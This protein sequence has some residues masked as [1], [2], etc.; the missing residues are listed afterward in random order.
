MSQTPQNIQELSKEELIEFLVTTFRRTL[1]HYGLWFREAEYQ[2]GMKQAMDAEDQAFSASFAIHM[3]RLSKILG[4]EVDP[5]GMPV[6]LLNQ[7]RERILK[8]IEAQSAN[9]LANDGVWFQAVENAHDMDTAKRCNDSC[10][11]RYSPYEAERIKRLLGLPDNS[12]L[13]G[14]KKAL[15]F[16]TYAQLNK[17]SFHEETENSFVFQMNECRVQVARQR[18]GLTDYPCRSAGKVEY[19]FFAQTID[20]RI[21]TECVG[22]PPDEH[23]AEWFCAWKFTLKA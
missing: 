21:E 2:L 1:I 5:K 19:R 13:E 20:S 15:N 14:L 8:L 3:K 4:F 23:P 10:W 11:T 22:C 12:G 18:K 16:R 17:Q 9:W 7:S 6:A